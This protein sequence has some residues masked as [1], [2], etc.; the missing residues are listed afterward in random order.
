LNWYGKRIGEMC[1]IWKKEWG[2]E[3]DRI[4]CVIAGQ[5]G[6]DYVSEQMLACPI[7]VEH[8]GERC[9]DTV[10]YFATAPYFGFVG[11]E[12]FAQRARPWVENADGGL[13]Q[14]FRELG[15]DV[16]AETFEYM[17]NN[18]NLADTYGLPLIAYEGGQHF[19]WE[20]HQMVEKEPKL[21]ELFWRANRDPRMKQLYLD[22][23]QAWKERGGGLFV[24]CCAV[25]QPSSQYG[26]WGY[27]EFQVQARTDAPKF[28]AIL[29][30]IEKNR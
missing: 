20:D 5:A 29:T 8:G 24:H 9:A 18:K 28:D 7:H 3:K 17:E 19:L 10:D 30:V 23:M 22:Y 12:E 4:K 16:L 11:G 15:S 6:W 21:A 14:F 26:S 13:D 1:Q 2:P 27:K 25:I